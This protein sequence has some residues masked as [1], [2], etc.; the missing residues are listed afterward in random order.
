[1]ALFSSFVSITLL[2]IWRAWDFVVVLV[3][4]IEQFVSTSTR[5]YT[6]RFTTGAKRRLKIVCDFEIFHKLRKAAW[7][8]QRNRLEQGLFSSNRLLMEFR[9]VSTE[10]WK[11]L[12]FQE[13]F[14]V[15]AG[16]P[17]AFSPSIL[18]R[19]LTLGC[20]QV[21]RGESCSCST[22]LIN[23][24]GFLRNSLNSSIA[25]STIPRAFLKSTST[26]CK[27]RL[28]APVDANISQKRCAVARNCFVWICISKPALVFRWFLSNE[29]SNTTVAGHLK[30]SRNER[31]GP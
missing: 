20:C 19:R 22:H 25:L 7:S 9:T 6:V 17:S 21:T 2:A 8:K 12:R 3:I 18:L 29:I 31:E 1:M 23:R 15:S 30:C 10:T 5:I 28:S 13:S 4:I 26:R 14:G 27:Y 11:V 24:S 16:S